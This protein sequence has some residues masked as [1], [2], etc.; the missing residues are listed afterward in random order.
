VDIRALQVNRGF[1]VSVDFPVRQAKADLVDSV[2][3]VDLVE[4]ADLA[5]YQAQVVFLE[6]VDIQE[7]AG[8]LAILGLVV[9]QGGLEYRA[10]QASADTQVTQVAERLDTAATVAFLASQA[11]R[12]TVGI[13]ALLVLAVHKVTGVLFG[14]LQHKLLL[15]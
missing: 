11:Y 5:E 12:D 10:F 13:L 1:Q 4:S 15:Q 2:A 9:F 14:T 6:S 7:L 8:I 3:T